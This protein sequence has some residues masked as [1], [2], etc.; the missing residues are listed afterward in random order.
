[1]PP[2]LLPVN[3]S[4]A[5]AGS[6]LNGAA[7]RATVGR[8]ANPEANGAGLPLKMEMDRGSSAATTTCARQALPHEAQ[9]AAR[10]IVMLAAA[11]AERCSLSALIGR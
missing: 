8:H 4:R 6:V 11:V 7:P 2:I 1:M 5:I 9:P 3:W 10:E